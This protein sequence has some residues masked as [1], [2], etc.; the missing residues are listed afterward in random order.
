M[1][2]SSTPTKK[3]ETSTKKRTQEEAEIVSN[4]TETTCNEKKNKARASFIMNELNVT[5]NIHI[6]PIKRICMNP[7]QTMMAVARFN[8]EIEIWSMKG[9]SG[10]T[11]QIT[12]AEDF[13]VVKRLPG[14]I[15]TSIETMIWTSDDRFFSAGLHGFVTE[16]DLEKQT[17]K[18]ISAVMGGAIWSMDYC[19][20]K[21]LIVI[22]CE[23]GAIRV[24]DGEDMS[25]KYF[26][27]PARTNEPPSGKQ[28]KHCADQYRLLTVKFIDN[29]NKAIAGGMTGLYCFDLKKRSSVYRVALKGSFCWCMEILN[30][31]IVVLGDSEGNVHF[32][33]YQLGAI[34]NSI[35]GHTGDVLKLCIQK[36]GVIY[37]TGVDGS[38]SMYKEVGKKFVFVIKKRP[39]LHDLMDLVFCE[40]ENAI[41]FGGLNCALLRMDTQVFFRQQDLKDKIF[42][43]FKIKPNRPL[44]K[45]ATEARI[46]LF[47][48]MANQITLLHLPTTS[49]KGKVSLN[50]PASIL[51]QVKVQSKGNWYSSSSDISPDGKNVCVSCIDSTYLLKLKRENSQSLVVEKKL[52]I[53]EAPYNV[54][55][56][57]YC[58]FSGNQYLVIAARDNTSIQIF[59]IESETVKT[60]VKLPLTK[61]D[62]EQQDSSFSIFA[63]SIN[64]LIANNKFV[65]VSKGNSVSA[66]KIEDLI[67]NKTT[68]HFTIGLSA[69]NGFVYKLDFLQTSDL[70]SSGF[71]L[72]SAPN[73]I[74]M[75]DAEQRQTLASPLFFP[76]KKLHQSSIYSVHQLSTD[77]CFVSSLSRSFILE[78]KSEVRDFMLANRKDKTEDM[79]YCVNISSNEMLMATFNYKMH[80]ENL[81]PVI[82]RKRFGT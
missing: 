29:G 57:H 41:Y 14:K 33:D 80:E 49:G 64:G 72:L 4:G 36:P 51:M 61:V 53:S 21:E 74:T 23:D 10:S 58:A 69:H 31:K 42:D 12:P 43:R 16:W 37:S 56:G 34:V 22:A 52:N 48:N 25:L 19:K 40:R 79:L 1:K 7:S 65:I 75:F 13:T 35:K 81:P 32:C 66:F 60:I 11:S 62:I 17:P 2:K 71:Y 50:D 45:I 82:N 68:P 15:G 39:S 5:N 67:A 30:D 27:A 3:G 59:D 70:S 76:T 38:I 54:T 46:G 9:H 26:I 6:S 73:T 78:D 77:S 8:S 20:E 44:L 24:L 55:P 63:N 47:D 28:Y 18:K